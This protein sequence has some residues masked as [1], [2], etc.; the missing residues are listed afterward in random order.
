MSVNDSPVGM[1]EFRRPPEFGGSGKDSDMYCTDSCDL[2]PD[3]QFVPDANGHGFIEPAREMS[4][5]DYQQE[6]HDTSRS[7]AV[8]SR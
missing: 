8:V 5:D 7:W 4:F 2:G 3:L 1:P 6:L